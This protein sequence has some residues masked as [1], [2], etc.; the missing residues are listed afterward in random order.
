MNYLEDTG[1]VCTEPGADCREPESTLESDLIEPAGCCE[2][3]WPLFD[4]DS[5]GE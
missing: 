2:P 1:M 3:E 5:V 4:F